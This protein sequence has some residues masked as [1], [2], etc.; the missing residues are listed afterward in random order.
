VQVTHRTSEILR[1]RELGSDFRWIDIKHFDLTGSGPAKELLA[2][3]IADRWYDDD[4]ASPSGALP[5]PSRGIHGP[6]SLDRIRVESFI[7]V[8]ARACF[9]AVKEWATQFGPLPSGFA[10]QWEGRVHALLADATAVYRL[11]ALG[12]DAEHQWGGHLG[13]LGFHEF[14]IVSARTRSVALLVASD[15]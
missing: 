11:P 2:A 4:Y 10:A 9:E 3:L 14:V 7:K 8:S 5:D 6:Y 12:A 13:T 1:F 15:D